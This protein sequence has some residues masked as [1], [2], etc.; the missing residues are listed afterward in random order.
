[1]SMKTK[2]TKNTKNTEFNPIKEDKDGVRAKRVIWSSKSLELAL[3]GI[4]DGK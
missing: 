4:M 1:M 3:K 2:N